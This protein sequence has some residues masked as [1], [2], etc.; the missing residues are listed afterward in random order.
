MSSYLLEA[1]TPASALLDD[2]QAR[3]RNA[4]AEISESGT[5]VRHV[6]SIFVPKD[7]TCFHLL[8]GPSSDAVAETAKRAGISTARITEAVSG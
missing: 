1:Y 4:A 2:I 5:P 7:E 6:R 3:V 8:D